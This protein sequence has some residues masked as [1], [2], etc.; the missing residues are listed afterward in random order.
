MR[1]LNLSAFRYCSFPSCLALSMAFLVLCDQCSEGVNQALIILTQ[2]RPHK[3]TQESG[4]ATRSAPL[5]RPGRR[6]PG[7]RMRA[8][9]PSHFSGW[10]GGNRLSKRVDRAWSQGAE[11]GRLCGPC[12][13]V[14][15]SLLVPYLDIVSKRILLLDAMLI[16]RNRIP[17]HSIPQ[18]SRF[19]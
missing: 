9:R 8:R 1:A 14:F 3:K 11:S 12:L 2:P 16:N 13:V 19:G 6:L 17:S 4:R 18:L 10:T 5:G 15:S 7:P